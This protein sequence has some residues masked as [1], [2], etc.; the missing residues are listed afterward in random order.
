MTKYTLYNLCVKELIQKNQ[1]CTRQASSKIH[2]ASLRTVLTGSDFHFEVLGQTDRYLDRLKD[3]RLDRQK[4]IHTDWMDNLFE[5]SDQCCLGLWSAS[6]IKNGVL[7]EGAFVGG[8][9]SH[10]TKLKQVI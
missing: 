8:G 5:N 7:A 1:C 9:K 6:W 10:G 2:S 3:G 4:D